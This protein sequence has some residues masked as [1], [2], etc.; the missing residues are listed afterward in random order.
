MSFR[1]LEGK[2]IVLGVTGSIAAYKAAELASSLAG[3]RADVH[4]AMTPSALHFVGPATF[5]ALTGHTPLTGVFDEIEERTVAH[6]ALVE[7]A[8]LLVIAPATGNIIGKIANGIADEIVSTLAMAAPCPVLLA[9]AMNTHMWTNP[10]VMANVDRLRNMGYHFVDPVEG[11]LACG[12]EGVGKMA[13][14]EQILQSVERLLLGAARHDWEDVPVLI[15]AGPTRE[16]IDPVRYLS[17]Y[18]TGSMGFAIAAAAQERGAEVTLV[19]GPTEMQPP[20]VSRLVRVQTASEMLEAVRSH[21]GSCRV[22]ISAAAVSDFSPVKSP[23]KLKK[24]EQEGERRTLE[25]QQTPDILAEMGRQK[26]N[27]ILVGFAL[28]TEDL[29]ANARQKLE[30]KNLDMIVANSAAEGEQPFGPGPSKVRFLTRG[31]EDHPLPLMSKQ[32]IAE[33]LLTF[34]RERFLQQG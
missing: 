4:V 5:R 3:L 13:P 32:E 14:V 22:L 21:F 17:N 18:S 9:P 31:G 1:S 10:I 15:T 8:D 19:T 16:P 30:G 25:L 33:H 34:I 11:R 7:N 12:Y 2:R 23:R 29:V 6:V 24:L 20:D 28:E 26:Q 27:Q